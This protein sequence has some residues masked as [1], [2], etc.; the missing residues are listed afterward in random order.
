MGAL[1]GYGIVG[2]VGYATLCSLGE[3]TAF[4]PISGSFPHYAARWADPALGFALG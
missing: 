2:T 1:L 4:A 3:M